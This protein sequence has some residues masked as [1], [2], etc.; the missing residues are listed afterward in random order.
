MPLGIA[1]DELRRHSSLCLW[2]LYRTP[3]RATLASSPWVQ[4]HA[5]AA[6]RGGLQ[7]GTCPDA[8][9]LW[10]GGVVLPT[11]EV[12]SNPLGGQDH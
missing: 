1:R 11:T 5:L 2:G 6:T 3:K 12:E 8:K 4:P 7:S 9:G 10:G